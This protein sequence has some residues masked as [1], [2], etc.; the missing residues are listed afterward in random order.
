MNI[1]RL[2]PTSRNP[3][4]SRLQKCTS[5]TSTTYT[6]TV[7]WV[8]AGASSRCLECTTTSPKLSANH[9]N[10]LPT[11]FLYHH[12]IKSTYLLVINSSYCPSKWLQE[13]YS[14]FSQCQIAS[15]LFFSAIDVVQF[16]HYVRVRLPR[17]GSRS[18]PSWYT[19]FYSYWCG[20]W[21]W[22]TFATKSAVKNCPSWG[23]GVTNSKN[24]KPMITSRKDPRT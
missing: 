11:Y 8:S 16:I 3:G 12:C 7:L 10:P 23:P 9:F 1:L 17:I 13:D 20:C 21:S 14:V 24:R 2:I 18:M 5:S 4:W 22:R 19:Y 15:A 6:N